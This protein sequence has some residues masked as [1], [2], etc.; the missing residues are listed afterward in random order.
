LQETDAMSKSQE[1]EI[2]Q[3]YVDRCFKSGAMDF[4]DLLLK[5][6]E[7]LT[8]FPLAKYQNVFDIF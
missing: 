1:C 5:T 2:Y 4:D 8:R 7:L 6:N 3:N